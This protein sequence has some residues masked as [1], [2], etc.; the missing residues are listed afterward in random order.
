MAKQAVSAQRVVTVSLL[1]DISDILLNLFAAVLSGSV[2]MLTQTLRG[3]ADLV[4]TIL[5]WTGV[6]RSKR[7]P[8][9]AYHFGYGRELYFWI[10][11]AGIS[12]FVLTAGLSIYFGVERLLRPQPIE[13]L[14]LAAAVLGIGFITNGYAL[15]LSL[16]RLGLLKRGL[17]EGVEKLQE[18]RLIETKSTLIVDGMGTAAS[19]A[20]LLALLAYKLAGD[21]RLDGLG[22][23][24]VGLICLPFIIG[25]IVEVKDAIAGRSASSSVE[26]A[27]INSAE[28]TESVLKVL[29]LKT[30]HLGSEELLVNMEVHLEPNLTTAQ[31]EKVMDNLKRRIKMRVASVKHIQVEVETPSR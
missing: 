4:T 14:R 27:I 26:D 2:V 17:R 10:L 9:K 15:S 29:D 31:I 22:A 1:V 8:D 25:L 20:G 12:M 30:M 18:S 7:R 28:G 24:V 3:A 21:L 19:L 16:R 6:Y 23:I 5:L 13:N 11:M